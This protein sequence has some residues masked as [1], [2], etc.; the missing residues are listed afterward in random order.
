MRGRARLTCA[1]LDCASSRSR[2]QTATCA[3]LYARGHA[4]LRLARRAC[5]PTR[6]R[7]R[8]MRHSIARDVTE[9]MLAASRRERRRR[10]AEEASRAKSRLLAT[11]SHEI[12]TPL[13][14][15]LG[16]SRLLAETRLSEEAE[17]LSRRHAAVRPHPGSIG[18]GPDRFFVACRRTVPAA[19]VAGGSAPDSRERVEM[20]RPA[21]TR[22]T[23]R[24]AQRSP[25][26]YPS[27]CSST[28]RGLRQVLF[29]VVATR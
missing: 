7:G 10:R 23:S 27:G 15:I 16:M 1:E 6:P 24:S 11:V 2:A 13:S 22:R 21:R 26:R 20:L 9:E 8:L 19:P 17:E 29:N 5:P 18:R 14:G 4:A 25:S 3:Y 12:R 28:R